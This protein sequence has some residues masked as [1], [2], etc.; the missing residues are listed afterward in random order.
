MIDQFG[1][2]GGIFCSGSSSPDIANN[3]ISGN[4]A[5]SGGG[6]Y[7]LFS[8]SPIIVNN[9]IIGNLA[10]SAGGGIL[11]TVDSQPTINNNTVAQ[12]AADSGGGFYCFSTSSVIANT[13]LWNNSAAVGPEIWVG[14]SS[15]PATLTISYS[16]VQGGQ[17]S[18]HVDTGCTL[19][20]GAGMIDANPLFADPAN[21]DYHLTYLS[22]CGNAGDAGSPG[23]PTEDFEGDPRVAW[24]GVDMGA[25]EVYFHLY[26]MGDATPGGSIVF[27][28]TGWPDMATNLLLG[29]GLREPSLPT[30]YG[31]FYLEA[32]ITFIH[33]GP[34][35]PTG[36]IDYPATI[37]LWWHA[38]ETYPFQALVGG[39]GWP[40]SRLS[41]LLA[42]TVE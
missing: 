28:I 11:C 30:M 13:I 19:D 12:N 14:E 35:P 29:T 34:I 6:I 7:C 36:I 26:H 2:G 31:D 22:P 38:G 1:Q 4:T 8:S 5:Y 21:G 15:N 3:R 40:S 18:V 25:D 9:T 23:L 17:S 37:P 10:T 32:P 27:R 20:W 24:N 39:F 16:D 41:N 42:L 33:L